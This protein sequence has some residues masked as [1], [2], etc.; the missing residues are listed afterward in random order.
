MAS[1]M[2]VRQAG[3]QLT[4]GRAGRQP[5]VPVGGAPTH[6]MSTT[7]VGACV[8]WRWSSQGGLCPRQTTLPA[9]GAE[10]LSQTTGGERIGGE[11][12]GGETTGGCEMRWDSAGLYLGTFCFRRFCDMKLEPFPSPRRSCSVRNGRNIMGYKIII[13]S[14]CLSFIHTTELFRRIIFFYLF[15]CYGN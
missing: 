1:L 5:R 10:L 9:R 7:S 3:Q 12:T 15:C 13:Y 6:C 14:W 2:T 11:T 4:A 8:P